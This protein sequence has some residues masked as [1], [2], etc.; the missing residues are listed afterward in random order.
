MTTPEKL[1][2][3]LRVPDYQKQLQDLFDTLNEITQRHTLQIPGGIFKL[4]EE[5]QQTFVNKI[6][7][8]LNFEFTNRPELHSLPV[9]AKGVG[10]LFLSDM[11]GN[12]L[13]VDKIQ[14]NDV[15]S[16]RI[17]EVCILPTPTTE[18]LL[19][20]D[21]AEIP[22]I[23]QVL[24]PIIVLRNGILKTDFSEEDGYETEHDLSNY[25]TCLPLAHYLRF[26][27]SLH[28]DNET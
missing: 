6:N 13:G 16:G 18:C 21:E 15:I 3:Q 5:K 24:S 11:E 27:A 22:L 4:D 17:E 26:T 20:S 25:Q 9:T 7:P 28:L 2:D 23:D 19:A 12:I 1:F 8:Y 10:M 14:E